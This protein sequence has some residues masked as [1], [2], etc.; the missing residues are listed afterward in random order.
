LPN[1]RIAGENTSE[2]NRMSELIAYLKDNDIK[3]TFSLE[4]LLTWYI[5]FYSEEEILSRYTEPFDRYPAYPQ[6]VGRAF[7][8]GKKTA[9]I[10]Y[11]NEIPGY[12][13][14]NPKNIRV[15]GARYFVYPNPDRALLKKLGLIDDNDPDRRTF[16]L[17]KHR[18]PKSILIE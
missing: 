15:V 8:E 2:E 11:S 10:G 5:M 12:L 9:I 7:D 6:A 13:L 3:F 18:D 4:A 17:L 14:R 16:N 1:I